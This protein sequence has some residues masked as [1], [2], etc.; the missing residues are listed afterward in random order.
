MTMWKNNQSKEGRNTTQ[1][2]HMKYHTCSMC[3]NIFWI[4]AWPVSDSPLLKTLH[5]FNASSVVFNFSLV[6]A[7]AAWMTC[8]PPAFLSNDA[9]LRSWYAIVHMA[10][11]AYA[12][13]SKLGLLKVFSKRGI[14]RLLLLKNAVLVRLKAKFLIRNIADVEA[15]IW[16]CCSAQ[17]KT[18][19]ITILFL[20]WISCLANCSPWITHPNIT[21]LMHTHTYTHVHVSNNST[22]YDSDWCEKSS[23][24][25]CYP[26][27]PSWCHICFFC[28]EWKSILLRIFIV[29]FFFSFLNLLL[30][31][32][33][34]GIMYGLTKSKIFS[35]V[36]HLMTMIWPFG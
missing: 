32:F 9:T 14:V 15:A 10:E 24:L 31:F 12:R 6:D 18:Y 29:G 17:S 21:L 19:G 22:T 35:L 5:P 13:A 2:G 7:S 4:Y 34:V 26:P 20:A 11:D 3:F 16:V 30:C 23:I 36:M 27:T 1:Q 8:K 33:I 28:K 25:S